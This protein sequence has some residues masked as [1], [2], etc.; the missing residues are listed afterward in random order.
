MKMMSNMSLGVFLALAFAGGSAQAERYLVVIK[1]KKVFSQTHS[2]VVLG[3]RHLNQVRIEGQA[4]SPFT[5]AGVQIQDSLVHLQTLVVSTENESQIRALKSSPLVAL[6]E[7]EIVH[8]APKPIQGYA[9]TQPWSFALK[10]AVP[11]SDEVAAGL[12][13]VGANTPWGITAVNAPQVWATGNQGQNSRIL[14]LDTGIDKDHPAL[15]ANFEGGRDFTGES[16]EPYPYVDHVGHGTHVSGTIAAV[17][18]AD[19]FAG[20]APRAK[21]IMGRVCSEDGCSSIAVV[22]GMNWAIEQKVDV[23]SM[24]LGGPIGSAAEKKA[25]EDLN[26][27]GISVVAAS[28][29]DGTPQVSYPAA[30]PTVVAVGAIDKTLNKAKFSQWG[31]QLSIVAPGVD[32]KSSVPQG[33]G[34]E[35][36]VSLNGMLVNS[37][38]FV[39]AP[40]VETAMSNDLVFAGLGKAEDF[41]GAVAGK[42]ALIR[43]GDIPF[44]EKV[45]N[46]INAKAAGVVIFNNEPGL[47]QGALSQD[48]STVAVPVVMIEQTSGEQ[49][50][51]I[52]D[53]GSKV[54][55]T[56]E[57]AASDYASFAGTSMATPHVAGVV[58]LLKTANK[59]LS[60]GQIKN[61]LKATA[62]P[63][64]P[65]T[66]NQYGAGIVNA[67]KAI[68][69]SRSLETI[70]F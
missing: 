20:V 32:V 51:I 65:N 56:V 24:S 9:R 18:A 5:A 37:T 41:T 7:K 19:G 12:P 67:E 30:F 34:R 46:A 61:I 69:A 2:Q 49:A 58:A 42:F 53:Q 3:A 27:A 25:A 1:D 44:S 47:I 10:Y 15:K 68:Q 52:L 63:K 54:R 57:T 11:A 59:A 31:P 13:R 70:A 4:I 14:V 66:E 26:A 60:P 62:T 6:V 40:E 29:N 39:G 35:S 45:A 43:R 28:G 38:S 17:M 36:K 50:K 8:P 55:A 48:G 23:V 21:L 22:T 64:T 33:T 16:S